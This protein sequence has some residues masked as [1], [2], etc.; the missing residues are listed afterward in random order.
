MNKWGKQYWKDL[1]ERVGATLIGAILAAVTVTG[2]T[3]V[4]W[5][6]GKAVWG[7]IGIPTLVSALK[8]LLVNLG[9]SEP[10]A[11]IVGVTSIREGPVRNMAD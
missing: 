6:D 5:G 2:T 4:D 8:S 9:G 10:T 3:G 1:G 11:S 7:I